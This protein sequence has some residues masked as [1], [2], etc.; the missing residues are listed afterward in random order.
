M[1]VLASIFSAIFGG[2]NW[3][4]T[5]TG[6]LAILAGVIYFDPALIDFSFFDKETQLNIWKGARIVVV[7]SA[8]IF[9]H[10][11]KDKNVTGGK[12]ASTLEASE[13]IESP[14]AT[15]PPPKPH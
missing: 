9:A 8:A 12:S 15:E 14:M 3:F 13:R 5:T 6:W 1:K 10:S 4:T 11:V 2:K 7:F